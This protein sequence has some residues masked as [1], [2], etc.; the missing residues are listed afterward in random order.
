VLSSPDTVQSA[1]AQGGVPA[2]LSGPA[3]AAEM[4][5]ESARWEQTLEARKIVVK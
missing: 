3:L 1:F 2:Y 4:N 5:R